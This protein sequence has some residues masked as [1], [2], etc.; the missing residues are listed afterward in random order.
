MPPM[1]VGV[2]Y[3]DVTA[4]KDGLYVGDVR[5]GERLPGGL[6]WLRPRIAPDPVMVTS[7]VCGL[8]GQKAS[9]IGTSFTRDRI[10]TPVRNG[11]WRVVERR[12][13]K[14]TGGIAVGVRPGG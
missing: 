3:L 14:Q 13:F 4:R 12:A 9:V 6:A 10:M 8:T 2:S 5:V 11:R 7:A 1:T